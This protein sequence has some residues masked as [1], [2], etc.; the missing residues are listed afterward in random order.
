[1]GPV[2]A[3]RIVVGE[4][5][6]DVLAVGQ[7]RAGGLVL[8]VLE[9][10]PVAKLVHHHVEEADLPGGRVAVEAVVEVEVG[11]EL[12]VAVDEARLQVG[13]RDRIGQRRAVPGGRE[14]S[15]GRSVGS[16]GVRTWKTWGAPDPSKKK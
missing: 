12:R 11:T 13:A 5:R 10:Q 6:V 15:A 16:D 3:G 8:E 4:D 1:M 14:R 7:E 2:L 9:A